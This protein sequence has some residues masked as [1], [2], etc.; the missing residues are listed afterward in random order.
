METKIASCHEIDND[1]SGA[2]T[3]NIWGIQNKKKGRTE[4]T[5]MYSISWNEYRKLQ[6]NGWLR[7]SNIR[8]SRMMFRTLSD[9]TTAIDIRQPYCMNIPGQAIDTYPLP[10]IY[11][12]RQRSSQY[13][14]VRRCAPCQM[15]LFQRHEAIWI[16][17]NWPLFTTKREVSSN[18]FQLHII[19]LPAT[20]LT[21]N[22]CHMALLPL[23]CGCRYKESARPWRGG[24]F[25]QQ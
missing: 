23:S 4:K 18:A 11:T 1:V 2:L 25:A 10:L 16:G 13:P 17:S 3:V 9:L 14:F 6:R 21:Q 8:R 24:N 12:S 19:F 15:H 22:I 5:H 7:C 20:H